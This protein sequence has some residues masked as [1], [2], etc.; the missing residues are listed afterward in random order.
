MSE[1]KPRR[2]WTTAEA[3]QVEGGWG[4]FLDERRLNTPGKLPL[5]VP[6]EALAHGIADEWAAQDQVIRPQDMPLTRAANTA[7]EQ[8]PP[9]FD[10]VVEMLSAYGGTDLLSYRADAPADL[11]ALQAAGWDPVLDWLAL[12]FDAR[13]AVTAGVIAVPQNPSALQNLRA[14]VAAQDGFSLTA[15]HDLVTL[16]GSLA[17]GLA[18]LH[19]RISVEDAIGLSRIDEEFQAE[20]WGRDEEADILASDRAQAIRNAARFLTLSRG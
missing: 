4:V 20:R 16:T 6:T 7:I 2:F 11:A 15:L 14:E 10:E 12:R 18:V 19:D 8:L 17:L 1:W 5:D 13:L 3:R 9:R